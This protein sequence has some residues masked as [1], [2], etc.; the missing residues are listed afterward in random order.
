[1]DYELHKKGRSFHSITIYVNYNRIETKD[2][3]IQ[4][5]LSFQKAVS[6]ITAY[7][8]SEAYAEKIAIKHMADFDSLIEQMKKQK[9]KTQIEDPAAYIV[10][11]FQKKGVLP[12]K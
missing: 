4:T 1:F 5:S 3:D 10:A 6:T 12:K 11:V 8:V 2:V 9:N 7:G